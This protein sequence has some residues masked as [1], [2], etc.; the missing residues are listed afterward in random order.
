MKFRLF[1]PSEPIEL[2]QFGGSAMGDTYAVSNRYLMRDG[3]PFVYRMGEMHFSRVP[4]KDWETELKKMKAGGIEIVASYLF[5]IHHEESEGE[6]CFLENCDLRRFLITCKKVGMPFFLRLGPWAHGEAR[7]GG[8]P[9]WVLQKCGGKEHTRTDE[10]PY[11]SLVRRYFARVYE[12]IKDC[13]DIVVGIQVENELHFN[14]EHMKTLYYMIREIG[15]SAPIWTAT[16]WGPGGC[17][18]NIPEDLLIPVYGGYPDAPWAMHIDPIK[19]CDTFHFSHNWNSAGIGTD[20]FGTDGSE[21]QDLSAVSYIGYPYLTCE[22]GGGNQVTYHRRPIISSADIAAGVICRL[23]SGVNGIGYYMY[24]GGKNPIGKTTMQESRAT[25]YKNDYPIVSYDFQS[26]IGECGQLRESYF[27][28][29][30]IHAFLDCCGETLAPM[31]SVLPDHRPADP[32][33]NATLR[34]AVRSDGM[35]GFLFFNNHTHA[36]EMQD[37]RETV[38]IETA[39]G[40]QIK[41]PLEIPAGSYGVV[42]FR[43]PI[44]AEVAEWVTAMP[45]S[46]TQNYIV[47][48]KIHGLDA[49]IC[50]QNGEILMLE[51]GM[52]LGGVTLTLQVT[53]PKTFTLGEVL[54][55]SRK[56]L[57]LPD[58]DFSHLENRDGTPLSPVESVDYRVEVLKNTNYLAIRAKGNVAA[59]YHADRLLADFFL[60]GDTWVV[61]VRK[62]QKP[63]DLTL[64]ILPLNEENKQKIYFET[65]MPCGVVIP[66]VYAVEF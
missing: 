43:F 47:F 61:D 4:A 29:R 8:F 33:D 37:I 16:G 54:R 34:C 35:R 18:A 45:V 12:E 40:T 63:T 5:W 26:P 55:V 66:E 62:L 57:A 36:E 32:C 30:T 41:I 27:E 1:A 58:T 22:V 10:E 11:L 39:D 9:D 56:K 23:G 6:Y 14:I 13:M 2:K 51:D 7:N 28:L 44:G 46:I 19:G 64:K 65:D 25:G 15:Y 38:L 21:S 50:L 52:T 60:Y 42:P 31:I 17:R 49:Q 48:E 20:I 53:A 59:I 3:K 24:H